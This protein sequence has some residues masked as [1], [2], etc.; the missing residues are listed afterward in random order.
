MDYKKLK[1]RILSLT[2]DIVFT[3][4]GIN[5]SICPVS[6]NLIYVSFGDADYE[7]TSLQDLEAA[8][9]F[10]GKMLPD[11]CNYFEF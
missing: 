9:V 11:I 7:Y 10:A 5:G 4:N 6:R 1:T 8:P 2:E 3:Y